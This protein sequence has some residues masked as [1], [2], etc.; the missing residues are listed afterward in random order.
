[1]LCD[2]RDKT[3]GKSGKTPYYAILLCTLQIM[4]TVVPVNMS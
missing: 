2:F 4:N 3:C 1:M